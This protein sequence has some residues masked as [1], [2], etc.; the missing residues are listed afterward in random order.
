MIL[1]WT[2]H[3]HSL[4]YLLFSFFTSARWQCVMDFL[5]QQT[6]RSRFSFTNQFK[7]HEYIYNNSF[8]PNVFFLNN[9]LISN[10]ARYSFIKL[11]ESTFHFNFYLKILCVHV[12]QGGVF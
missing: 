9:S 11:N 12:V 10:L 1:I 6:T 4:N 3:I 7:C 5:S 2:F 8:N